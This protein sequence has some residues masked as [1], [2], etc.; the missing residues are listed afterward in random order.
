MKIRDYLKFGFEN[1][2]ILR[3]FLWSGL[4]GG[5]PFADSVFC[6]FSYSVEI[7]LI[8]ENWST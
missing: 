1:P 6:K 2:D 8:R 3:P 5:Q 4:Q 7:Q